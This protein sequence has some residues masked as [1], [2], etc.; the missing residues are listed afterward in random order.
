VLLPLH[1]ILQLLLDAGA[2][3]NVVD[4]KGRTPLF[5]AARYRHAGTVALLL[6][7]QADMNL[8][9]IKDRTPLLA[10]AEHGHINT[11]NLL[12]EKGANYLA[13]DK[14]GRSALHEA[15][16]NGHELCTSLLCRSAQSTGF[17]LCFFPLLN[18]PLY[19]MCPELIDH[20]D[21]KGVTALMTASAMS[22]PLVVQRLID[23]RAAINSPDYKG[24]TP[25]ITAVGVGA[26]D[27]VEALC[28]AGANLALTA[29]RGRSALHAAV[30]CVTL[31]PRC[32]FV[33]LFACTTP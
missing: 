24:R 18:S 31:F 15:A 20:R 16:Q 7:R 6:C 17:T 12:L 30:E 10:A 8:A 28:S 13:F 29:E 4:D 25:L 14:K 33:T 11:I 3:V 21:V 9:D 22:H 19:S 32:I 5:S 23:A 1:S 27:V 2:A 26:I